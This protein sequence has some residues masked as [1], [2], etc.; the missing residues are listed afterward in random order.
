MGTPPEASRQLARTVLPLASDVPAAG[1]P[2]SEGPEGGNELRQRR[3]KRL[4]PRSGRPS[5]PRDR[6]SLGLGNDDE[7]VDGD[8]SFNGGES[9]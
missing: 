6:V 9:L 5:C 3:A 2:E 7:G 8:A 1:R 4:I